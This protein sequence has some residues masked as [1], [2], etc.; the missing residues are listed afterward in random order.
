[1]TFINRGVSG[2]TLADL[3]AR[4]PADT[5]ALKPDVLSI[6]IGVNDVGHALRQNIPVSIASYE[7]TYDRLLADTIAALPKVKLVL[8]EPFLARGKRPQA[9]F[10]DWQA[11]IG[12]MDGVVDKLASKYHAPVVRFKRMFDAASQ[13]APAGYWIWDGV[14][15][16]L[17]HQLMADEWE[18]AY[19][20]FYGSSRESRLVPST[21]GP[22]RVQNSSPPRIERHSRS[23][24]L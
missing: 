12:A 3:V 5:I 13:R 10:D 1:M 2:N 14:H 17:G 23:G 22:S 16:P 11:A 7:R 20:A 15:P 18:R 19:R 24:P 8:C 4:W 6:L 21:H 9:R